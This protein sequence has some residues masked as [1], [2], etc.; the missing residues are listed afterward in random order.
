MPAEPEITILYLNGQFTG[1]GGCNR[2][3][4]KASEGDM[5]GDISVGQIGSTY[6]LQP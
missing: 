2:Y 1:S 4:A 3:F 5:A 6:N